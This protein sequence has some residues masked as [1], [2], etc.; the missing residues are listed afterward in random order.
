MSVM[1]LA[2]TLF[3]F[4]IAVPM[5]SPPARADLPDLGGIKLGQKYKKA[6][7]KKVTL[8]G[9]TGKLY[10]S[11]PDKGKDKIVNKVHFEADKC[12]D[13]ATADAITKAFGAP[14]VVN[15]QGDRLWEGTTNAVLLFKIDYSN[16]VVVQLVP[17]QPDG[18]RVCWAKDGFAEFWT[19][20][21][22]AVGSGKPAA[23]AA[24]SFVFPFKDD[25]GNFELKNAKE[26]EAKWSELVSA[27]DAKEI[28]SGAMTRTCE[29]DSQRYAIFLHDPNA[30]LYA[31]RAADGT[32]RWTSIAF[33]STD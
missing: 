7:P 12:S 17:P 30:D 33:E 32:W 16:G 9:C 1:K 13:T 25:D 15:A 22:K 18:K 4:V 26:L 21:A 27:D 10:G 31:T 20:F 2:A 28:T 29:H 19:T 24:A 8:Y 5:L 23:T 14:P 6:K 11:A 3:A